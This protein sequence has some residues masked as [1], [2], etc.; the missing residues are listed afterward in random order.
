MY[1][2]NVYKQDPLNSTGRQESD[3]EYLYKHIFVVNKCKY[4]HMLDSQ[5]NLEILVS[6]RA[7]S[8]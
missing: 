7:C 6:E 1:Y 2:M 4:V 3:S 5:I 8:F